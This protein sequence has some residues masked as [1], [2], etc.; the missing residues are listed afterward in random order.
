MPA[1]ESTQLTDQTTEKL[2]Q[3]FRA[4]FELP[5]DADVQNIRQI[6]FR[7]WDSLGHVL[8]IS[9]IESEFGI[10]LELATIVQLT[11]FESVQ[12][13]LTENAVDRSAVH[14]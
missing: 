13:Y 6:S 3:V 14:G 1:L 7:K 12:L 9:A 5:A 2:E 4:V 10:Q 8:L 11:S